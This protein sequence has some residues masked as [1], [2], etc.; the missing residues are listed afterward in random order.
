M[1]DVQARAGRGGGTGLNAGQLA[2][3]RLLISDT[4]GRERDLRPDRAADGRIAAGLPD[5]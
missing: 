1:P 2:G 5:N 4:A 3:R